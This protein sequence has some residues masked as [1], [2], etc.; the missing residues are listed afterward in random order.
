VSGELDTEKE[1]IA[2]K[3]NLDERWMSELE[4]AIKKV[5]SKDIV[6][7]GQVPTYLKYLTK[8]N[9]ILKSSTMSWQS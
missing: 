8:K 6:S 9:K 5:M 4:R 7:V 1:L 3:Y 2:L